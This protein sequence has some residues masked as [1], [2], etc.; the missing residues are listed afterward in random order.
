MQTE[1]SEKQCEG[2]QSTFVELDLEGSLRLQKV[3]K[4][5]RLVTVCGLLVLVGVSDPAQEETRNLLAILAGVSVLVAAFNMAKRGLSK[6]VII[7][8]VLLCLA[9]LTVVVSGGVNA[10]LRLGSDFESL[11]LL[12]ALIP[13]V[14]AESILYWVMYTDNDLIE[15]FG[16]GSRMWTGC[17]FM[18]LI[19]LLIPLTGWLVPANR[20]WEFFWIVGGILASFLLVRTVIPTALSLRR[21]ATFYPMQAL[22][23]NRKARKNGGYILFLVL[24]SANR[25]VA[26][27]Y[28]AGSLALIVIGYVYALALGPFR[29]LEDVDPMLTRPLT[30][31]L[32]LG[33]ILYVAALAYRKA[34]A[35]LA[36][37]IEP[38]LVEEILEAGGFT[39]YLRSFHDDES[40][41]DF[42]RKGWRRLLLFSPLAWSYQNVFRFVRL[43][44]MIARDLWTYGPVLSVAPTG[45]A[46]E[47]MPSL[48]SYVSTPVGAL[49]LNL[50]NESWKDR[51]LPMAQK[52]ECIVVVVAGT[53]GL[54][55]EFDR[56]AFQS[57]LRS[58]MVLLLPPFRPDETNAEW[59]SLLDPTS[60]WQALT[61]GATS[62]PRIPDEK[63]Q[64]AAAIAF[65]VDG[66]AALLTAK[67]ASAA[68]FRLALQLARIL[69]C[70]GGLS[71]NLD[72]HAVSLRQKTFAAVA[73]ALV[74]F[75]VAL[76]WASLQVHRLQDVQALLDRGASDFGNGRYEEAVNDYQ[77]ALA[78]N[79]NSPVAHNNLGLVL[80]IRG[81]T[82]GQLW[83]C[84]KPFGLCRTPPFTTLL[85]RCLVTKASMRRRRRNMRRPSR[86]IPIFRAPIATF[87]ASTS[88]GSSMT[89]PLLNAKR[90]LT[91]IQIPPSHT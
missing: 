27:L 78:I 59:P 19:I 89:R 65:S 17:L 90:A 55:W 33:G 54:K 9:M 18:P 2:R 16:P 82:T 77:K 26:F 72:E 11:N 64:R 86:S 23:R 24:Q 53:P 8:E 61:S 85:G 5:S 76:S 38:A 21:A 37:G 7:I 48:V 49:Q 73:G 29:E 71:P 83:K 35:A 36:Q 57:N 51:I 56:L 22:A 52:A 31:V 32:V 63:L 30:K 50:P 47:I 1:L 91:W 87:V 67:E 66:S 68:A 25:M 44:E 34:L 60:R 15:S 20:G 62:V 13:C 69:P 6:I 81:A 43:E 3:L 14:L 80:T 74:C 4:A 41:F 42:G 40:R 84:A 75:A 79:S 58:K 88:I 46:R 12:F 39:L 28:A 70:E 45:D 10:T